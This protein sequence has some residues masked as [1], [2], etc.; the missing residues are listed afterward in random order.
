MAKFSI[1]QTSSPVIFILLSGSPAY[2]GAGLR[3]RSSIRPK[4]FWNK[5]LGTATSANRN[6]TYRPWLTT[7]TPIF[8]N[9]SHSVVSDQCSTCFGTAN[10]RKGSQADVDPPTA[11]GPL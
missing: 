8:T 5:L 7:F 6:V 2:A 9:F 10:V 1:I 3:R 11:N 4:I